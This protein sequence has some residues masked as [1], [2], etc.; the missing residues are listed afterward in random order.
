MKKA[1][2]IPLGIVAL[3]AGFIAVQRMRAPSRPRASV[4]AVSDTASIGSS[5][6]PLPSAASTSAALGRPPEDVDATVR[7]SS[8]PAPVRNVE[9]VR[10]QLRQGEAGTYLVSMLSQLDSSLYRWNDRLADPLRVWVAPAPGPAPDEQ[11]R[12]VRSAFGEWAALGI[13]VRFTFVV[14]RGDADIVVNWVD[15]FTSD[16]RVGNTRWVHDQHLWMQPGTEI[17]LATHYQ[18]GQPIRNE[19]IHAIAM[20]EVGHLLGMPHSPD[21]TDIMFPRM[22]T[23]R[24]SQ[25]DRAT[26][27]LLYSVSAGSLK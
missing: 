24:L 18:Q 14:Q 7:I 20:H 22:H 5:S 2:F 26:V 6:E 25:A 4:A 27:R 15:R 9:D 10:R 12:G 8:G 1:D 21:T 23:P 16:N 13:P 19:V 11:A 17:T 3:L